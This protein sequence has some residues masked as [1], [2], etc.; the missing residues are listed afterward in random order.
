LIFDLDETLIHTLRDTTEDGEEDMQH[1][2]Y[3]EDELMDRQKL[4]WVEITEP[5]SQETQ[6]YAI[7]VRPFV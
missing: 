3:D 6:K 5:E 4:M 2:F 7:Y 1:Q